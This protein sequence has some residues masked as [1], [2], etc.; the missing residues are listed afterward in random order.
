MFPDLT[1]YLTRTVS[2]LIPAG[3]NSCF[4][5]CFQDA[6]LPHFLSPRPLLLLASL[7]VRMYSGCALGIFALN[8]PSTLQSHVVLDNYQ[9][10]LGP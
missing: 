2:V 5:L 3:S 8:A 10:P 9:L 1:P 4:C 6:G 7:Q